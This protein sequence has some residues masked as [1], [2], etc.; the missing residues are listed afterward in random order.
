M[1]VV[2]NIK[3]I[4]EDSVVPQLRHHFEGF[5]LRGEYYCYGV[6]DID[7]HLSHKGDFY[8]MRD[9]YPGSPILKEFQDE[10]LTRGINRKVWHG[11]CTP[12]DTTT[13]PFM[14]KFDPTL[15]EYMDNYVLLGYTRKG[16]FVILKSGCDGFDAIQLLARG[17]SAHYKNKM[18]ETCSK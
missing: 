3:K 14:R 7:I 10:L 9:F 12:C 11:R 2:D 13:L 8:K 6:G 17:Y 15:K 4:I 5:I 16:A 1:V 18:I